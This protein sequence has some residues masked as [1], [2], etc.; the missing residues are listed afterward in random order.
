VWGRLFNAFIERQK[1]LEINTMKLIDDTFKDLR[2]SEGAFD[3]LNNFKNID[4]LP[5]ISTRLQQKYTDVLK[6]YRKELVVYRELFQQG[7]SSYEDGRVA[8]VISRGKP[9]VAGIISWAKSLMARMKGPIVKF[10]KNEEKFE[11]ELFE[12]I[13]KEY[14]ELVKEID[15]YQQGKYAGWSANIM[16]RAMQ[17]LKEKI[18]VKVG[19]NR[20]EVNFREEFRVLIQ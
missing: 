2:S 5:E 6:S 20:Y 10:N 12:E 3:L 1:Q 19:E 4:T 15:V 16:E 11:K 14:L 18:L 7:K 9:P 8:L 13:K 17:F